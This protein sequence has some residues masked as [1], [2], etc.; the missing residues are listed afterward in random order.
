MI[1]FA[2]Y[3]KGG[4]GKSTIA[5]NVSAALATKGLTV[6]QIGCDPKA[7]STSLLHDGERIPTVLQ[8]TREKGNA[9]QL[10]EIVRPGAGGVLCV[11]AGGPVPGLGCAGRGIINAL[12]TLS[13]LGAYEVYKPDV[14]IYD[15]LGDVVC[16]GFS[17]PMRGGYADR[18]FVVTS[19]EKMSVYAA[20][21][22]C[23]AVQNFQ[24]RGYASL[25]GILLNRRGVPEEDAQ[26]QALA[27]DFGTKILAAIDR[28]GDIVQAE[29]LAKPVSVVCP[30]SNAARQLDAAAQAILEVCGG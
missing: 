14:V 28:S 29:R 4:I 1:R 9:L 26:A 13:R 11:E 20:A 8:L 25:G 22:I 19:G 23:M 16:G 21:N 24:G 3:G 5:C 7:D 10:D 6:M 27:E 15:V 30:D 12:E 17:M 18:I 2:I